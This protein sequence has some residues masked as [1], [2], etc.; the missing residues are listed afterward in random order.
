MNTAKFTSRED[1]FSVLDLTARFSFKTASSLSFSLERHSKSL[2]P[3]RQIGW[4]DLHHP[5]GGHIK[6]QIR[7][8]LPAEYHDPMK[9]R[10]MVS[11]VLAAAEIPPDETYEARLFATSGFMEIQQPVD[12]EGMADRL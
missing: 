9:L 4:I 6:L 12:R 8:A 10:A 3:V 2:L 5:C 1:K 7:I 11:A